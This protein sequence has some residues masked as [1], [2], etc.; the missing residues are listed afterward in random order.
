MRY[1]FYS[2]SDTWQNNH[3]I[4]FTRQKQLT[5]TSLSGQMVAIRPSCVNVLLPENTVKTFRMIFTTKANIH[6]HHR[7]TWQSFLS[8]QN[9]ITLDLLL[10]KQPQE[11][12]IFFRLNIWI[13][14][15]TCSNLMF[16]CNDMLKKILCWILTKK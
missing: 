3:T 2:S 8:F 4:S 13:A 12:A 16:Y 11:V 1:A 15:S 9:L 5:T 7:T 6:P 10:P 14:R